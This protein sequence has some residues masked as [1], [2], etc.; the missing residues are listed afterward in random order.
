MAVRFSRRGF[1]I[2]GDQSFVKIEASHHDGSGVCT[3]GKDLV[4][5]RRTLFEEQFL[6]FSEQIIVNGALG[7]ILGPPG[8]GKS[9][10]SFAFVS[11]LDKNEWAV[12]WVH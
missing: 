10:T 12:V 3:L 11:S 4:L 1:L 6:F 8:T 2:K 5:F 9:A 7:W